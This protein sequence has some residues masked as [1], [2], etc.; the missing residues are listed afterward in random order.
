M[1][2]RVLLPL[3]VVIIFLAAGYWYFYKKTETP[4]A[5]LYQA[6]PVDAALIVE[7]RNYDAFCLNLQPAVRK[8]K[9]PLLDSLSKQLLRVEL[10]RKA[11]P[12][13]QGLF[14]QKNSVLA[15]F[16][17]LGEGE[18][19]VLYYFRCQNDQNI[20]KI[21]GFINET[22][23]QVY[24]L[25]SRK[26]ENTSIYTVVHRTSQQVLSF[27]CINGVVVAGRSCMLIEKAIRQLG[28]AESV[29]QVKGLGEIVKTAG[30]NSLANI[31][32]N[33]D[34]LP[35]IAKKMVVPAYSDK[36]W[37]MRNFGSWME[38]DLF[39]KPD[40]FVLNGFTFPNPVKPGMDVL[41]RNQ[42]PIH[43]EITAK[44][45]EAVNT[46]MVLGISDLNKYFEDYNQFGAEDRRGRVFLDS[47]I[48]NYDI[49]L[50]QVFQ[51]IFEDEA[52]VAFANFNGDTLANRAFTLIRINNRDEAVKNLDALVAAYAAKKDLKAA[53]FIS[54]QALKNGSKVRIW[55]LPFANIPELVFGRL[56]SAG[57][58]C[59]CALLDNY[60]LF[61]T[62][63][64]AIT[65]YIQ[66]TD[67][68]L[69]LVNDNGFISLS[70]YFSTQTN[71]FLY[72]KPFISGDFYPTYFDTC[73][74][75][76]IGFPTNLANGIDAIVY[77]L[78]SAEN[79]RIYNS[80]FV[81]LGKPAESK[82]KQDYL[83]WKFKLNGPVVFGPQI[84]KDPFRKVNEILVQDATNTLFLFSS[85]GQPLWQ[86]KLSGPILGGCNQVDYLKNGKYQFL[87]NTRD[88]IYLIDRKA[89]SV[90]NYPI[91]LKV[92]ASNP[93]SV[94]DYDRNR[95][96]RLCVATVDRRVLLLDK[97]SFPIKG[98]GFKHT[99]SLVT[100][101]V[102][103]CRMAGKDFI[104]LNDTTQPYFL[105][106]KGKQ[107]FT[108]GKDLPVARNNGIR[109][110]N[111][112]SAKDARFVF[113]DPSGK[114]H[115]V[116]PKGVFSEINLGGYSSGFWFH[117]ADVDGD[118][119][120]EYVFAWSNKV[121][122]LSQQQKLIC[123]F[124]TSGNITQSPFFFEKIFAKGS[125]GLLA[126]SASKI[127]LFNA[128]GFAVEGFPL[129]GNSI[130]SIDLLNSQEKKLFLVV[131]TSDNFLI[132]Y[133]IP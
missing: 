4:E 3:L 103:Y 104:F 78:N 90:G 94:F 81:R 95:D 6:I 34:Q 2:K 43:L 56:F 67:D 26:Y 37:F 106:R 40:I 108:P 20:R 12:E 29:L 72:N 86:T 13:I 98:W 62:D 87:F 61:G 120:K 39:A 109:V 111:S 92:P 77:Q 57:A 89:K 70:E 55:A 118:G 51:N 132:N 85:N 9:I 14:S 76:K 129:N 122:V 48:R 41:F 101:P 115:S 119:R 131:G 105:D 74:L 100:E 128:N 5:N 17:L 114:L 46:F 54:E 73:F 38:L 65:R 28:C 53:E 1:I 7:I 42:K 75:S 19:D 121:R 58:N 79:L 93:I 69:L 84:V 82:G 116:T 107:V 15:S 130:F 80:V 22:Q 35:A 27:A 112:H 45:P 91:K 66:Q 63:P 127:Y 113:A 71:F 36:L 133:V 126:G 60:L 25:Q 49:D 52:C 99:T 124:S 16:H 32:I 8:I 117:V 97:N 30:K 10:W 125:I 33:F 11:C 64:E 24:E 96:Y 59:Y 18:M 68:K 44:I 23:T 88:Y 21:A 110:I 50:E 123:E 83:K 47:L 31:Y 102:Q